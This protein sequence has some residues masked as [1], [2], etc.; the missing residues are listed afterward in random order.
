MM[1]RRFSM[2]RWRINWLRILSICKRS[3]G[4]FSWRGPRILPGLKPSG[5]ILR[6]WNRSIWRITLLRPFKSSKPKSSNPTITLNPTTSS[7][8]AAPS[9]ISKTMPLNNN[10]ASLNSSP[11]SKKS[12]I[13]RHKPLPPF[14]MTPNYSKKCKLTTKIKSTSSPKNAMKPRKKT[15]SPE[16]NSFKFSLY[17]F[18]LFQEI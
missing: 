12:K 7:V 3:W 14:K 5:P 17:S 8:P 10:P 6:K 11:N 13:K 2:R 18:A 16:T 9:S 1:L 4:I 15:S